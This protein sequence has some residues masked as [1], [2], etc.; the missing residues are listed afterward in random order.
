MNPRRAVFLDRD[1][2]I[3]VNRPDHVK[4]WDEFIFLPRVLDAIRRLASSEFVIVIT[5]NQSAIN[6]GTATEADI[7]DIH[8]RMRAEIERVG[9]RI[10]AVY[11]CPHKPDDGCECRKPKPGMFQRA[12]RELNID[13]AQSIVV[14]DAST[15]IVAAQTIG[16][17]PI[18]VLTGRGHTQHDEMTRNNHAGYLVVD[19]LLQAVEWIVRQESLAS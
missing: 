16:A 11:H 15:D 12:A 18:L 17:K 3:N 6:R 14:G 13:L 10:E 8:Q 4:S 9:G 19:D 7:Q 5:T 1:G 2:V